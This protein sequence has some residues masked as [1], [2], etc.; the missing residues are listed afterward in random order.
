M[1]A[2]VQRRQFL[3]R[4][5]HRQPHQT[6]PQQRQAPA[7]HR[8][9]PGRPGHRRRRGPQAPGQLAADQGDG[10]VFGQGNQRAVELDRRLGRPLQERHRIAQQRPEA[11]D[12]SGQ[13]PGIGHRRQ[14]VE[15]APQLRLHRVE[16][17]GLG[18]PQLEVRPGV[19][20]AVEQRPHRILG[21]RQT[22]R[23]RLAQLRR[24]LGQEV[25]GQDLALLQGLVEGLFRHARR[26]GGNGERPRQTVPEL[27]LELLGHDHALGRHLLDRNQDVVQ[28]LPRQSQHAGRLGR[29]QKNL[30][31]L[32]GPQAG[33]PRRGT[34]LAVIPGQHVQGQP[35]LVRSPHHELQLPPGLGHIAAI[36]EGQLIG[37]GLEIHPRRHRAFEQGKSPLHCG[38]AGRH[39]Q[40]L[41]L[42]PAQ[43]LAGHRRRRTDADQLQTQGRQTGRRRR[44]RPG[45]IVGIGAAGLEAGQRLLHGGHLAPDR[46]RRAHA[47]GPQ[48]GVDALAGNAPGRRLRRGECRRRLA[49]GGQGRAFPRRH[50][51]Q[52]LP[53]QGLLGGDQALRRRQ[54]GRKI[55]RRG[56]LPLRQGGALDGRG[57]L[58]GRRA[59]LLQGQGLFLDRRLGLPHRR[60]R[61]LHPR[62]ERLGL[63][64]V[65]PQR[66]G[67]RLGMGLGL[68]Q[69]LVGAIHGRLGRLEL[70]QDRPAGDFQAGLELGRIG[71]QLQRQGQTVSHGGTPPR[72]Q[73]RTPPTDKTRPGYGP[74]RSAGRR[75][76]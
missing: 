10:A 46:R 5:E 75:F 72:R 62:R 34:E 70:L 76:G 36:G 63:H 1:Q 3:D 41:A 31:G 16:H 9:R 57:I 4:L 28:F 8:R 33:S 12:E 52:H 2:L 29:R 65:G 68:V 55:S 21:R 17:P 20:E 32:R 38:H 39:R 51:R 18:Q 7:Q 71:R 53:P 19:L 35:Q 45:H 14:R 24:E 56:R 54:L 74:G 43:G 67:H 22:P 30:P 6:A 59:G 15:E 58:L 50:R 64:A 42:Q 47:Q 73:S 23:H 44:A 37:Q 25:S 13:L 40:Q 11:L 49:L 61:A 69:G 27:V 48:G 66:L 26:L 60:R